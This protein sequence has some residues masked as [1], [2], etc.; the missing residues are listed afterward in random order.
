MNKK[1]ILSLILAGVTTIGL[2]QNF[3][4]PSNFVKTSPALAGGLKIEDI[5]KC[6]T[7]LGQQCSAQNQDPRSF[8]QCANSKMG[9]IPECTQNK[10]LYDAVFFTGINKIKKFNNITVVRGKVLMADASEAFFIV[11]PA[12]EIISLAANLPIS[13]TI[14]D[15]AFTQ[16]HPRA[17]LF[18]QTR[19]FPKAQKSNNNTRLI[20]LQPIKECNACAILG[21]GEVAYD[22]S[23][24]GKLQDITVI[25]FKK[26]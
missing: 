15:P 4:S 20:F 3:A 7:Q 16:A 11:T 10:A 9:T 22:I 25:G 8:Q 12:G 24:D 21:Y 13:Q 6:M 19:D 23:P 1:L 2:A 17:S 5:K 18:N 26:K 14:G